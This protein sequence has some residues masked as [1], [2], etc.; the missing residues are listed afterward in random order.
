MSE[1]TSAEPRIAPARREDL[2]AVIALLREARLP[3]AGVAQHFDDFL[4]AR[5]DQEIVGAVGL[6]RYGAGALLRSLVVAPRYRT[7]GLGRSLAERM[8]AEA[9]ARG[10]R[11]VFLLTETAGDWFPRLG[12]QCIAREAIDPPVQRSVEF[13]TTCCEAAVAMRLDL[14]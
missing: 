4:V 5:A 13:T 12:F 10:A 7:R 14:A 6:E 3:E 8:L 2:A 11:T 1:S 9:R